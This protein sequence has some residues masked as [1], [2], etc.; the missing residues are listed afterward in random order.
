MKELIVILLFVMLLTYSIHV[1]GFLTENGTCNTGKTAI[2][3]STY[4]LNQ[5]Y[6]DFIKN[7]TKNNRPMAEII[8]QD[9]IDK[10]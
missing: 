3:N 10:R 5:S 7:L 1:Y 2:G 4:I 6:E 8:C 9:M